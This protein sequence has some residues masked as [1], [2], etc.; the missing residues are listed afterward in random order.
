MV[1]T[2]RVSKA[3]LPP[4]RST[5]KGLL[6]RLLRRPFFCPF[7]NTVLSVIDWIQ[8][9][10]HEEFLGSGSGKMMQ[11]WIGNIGYTSFL[12]GGV[13]ISKNIL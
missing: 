5:V 7:R 6:P 1:I 2:G 3:L 9:H 12:S 13:K 11:I 10:F 8:I 4:F